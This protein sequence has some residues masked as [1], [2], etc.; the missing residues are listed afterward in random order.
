MLRSAA[1]L[2]LTSLGLVVPG[3]FATDTGELESQFSFDVYLDNSRIGY[4]EYRLVERPDG[5]RRLEA[6]ARFDVKFLFVNAFRYRH[7]IEET[8]EGNC[9]TGVQARTD[10]NGKKTSVEGFLTEA[11]FILDAGD[12]RK[13]LGD[14]VMTFAY[15]NP[16]FL[17]ADRLLNPQTGEFLDVEIVP[18]QREALFVDGQEIEARCYEITSRNVTVRVWYSVDDERW[19][20]LE[21]PTRGGRTLRYELNI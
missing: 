9:L 16:A 2:T 19:L 3:A 6:E 21:S 13:D 18:L 4:H 11:G 5:V 14:C 15:W 12:S 20:A 10:S 7:E 17:E 1:A 8:W